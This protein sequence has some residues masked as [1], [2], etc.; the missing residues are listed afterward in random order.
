[1]WVYFGL[2][3]WVISYIGT[4]SRESLVVEGLRFTIAAGYQDEKWTV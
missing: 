2:Q 3:A 1:M 4:G